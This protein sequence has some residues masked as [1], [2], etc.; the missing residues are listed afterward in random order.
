MP[1]LLRRARENSAIVGGATEELT[2]IGAEL[3]RRLRILT[4]A[5]GV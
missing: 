3:N 1:Y 4:V 2:M 5:V